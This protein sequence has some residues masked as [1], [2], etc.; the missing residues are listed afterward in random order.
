V[1]KKKAYSKD[2]RATTFD[3]NFLIKGMSIE[4]VQEE[5]K[6]LVIQRR[7]EGLTTRNT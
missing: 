3:T 6:K 5:K 4:S 7:K 1:V 2:N